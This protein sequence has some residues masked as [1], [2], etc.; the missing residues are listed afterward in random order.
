MVSGEIQYYITACGF[1]DIFFPSNASIKD[2]QANEWQDDTAKWAIENGFLTTED[3]I[4]VLAYDEAYTQLLPGLWTKFQIDIAGHKCPDPSSY[5]SRIDIWT[6]LLWRWTRNAVFDIDQKNQLSHN[7]PKKIRD[8]KEL[9]HEI[10]DSGVRIYLD[11]LK[12]H[13]SELAKIPLPA[14]LFPGL[15]K[16]AERQERE[17]SI[18]STKVPRSENSFIKDGSAYVIK[19][20]GRRLVGLKGIGYDYIH[21]LVSRPYRNLSAGELYRTTR[22]IPK[23]DAANNAERF[24]AGLKKCVSVQHS[25]DEK[26]IKQISER[27]REIKHEIAT[28]EREG[29]IL[30]LKELKIEKEGIEKY[31]RE[32]VNPHN[33]IRP[34]RDQ[35]TRRQESIAKA[36]NRAITNLEKLDDIIG[37]HFKSTLRPVT[38][39]FCYRP[40]QEIHWETV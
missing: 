39:P 23:T 29:D 27:Y 22:A 8:C 3:L 30:V 4:C 7:L 2:A 15:E 1:G 32:T 13:F 36:I 17:Q 28:A 9:E 12:K 6:L 38:P 33:R 25:T 40:D 16:E 37:A 31:L 11:D 14:I 21:A 20:G 19:Y 35:T 26:T 18:E 5:D 24:D 34:V 10:R